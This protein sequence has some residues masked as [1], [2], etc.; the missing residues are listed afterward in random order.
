VN[1]RLLAGLPVRDEA[2]DLLG[3]VASSRLQVHPGE[4]LAALHGRT[5]VAQ[6][7]L[8]DRHIEVHVNPR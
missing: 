3:F 6:G 1:G 4:R 8:A 5:V 7:R 2:E